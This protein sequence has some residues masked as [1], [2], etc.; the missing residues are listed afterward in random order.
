MSSQMNRRRGSSRR[1]VQPVPKQRSTGNSMM[2][3][4]TAPSDVPPT[5]TATPWN[6]LTVRQSLRTANGYIKL[7]DLHSATCTQLGLQKDVDSSSM[8][9]D[10]RIVSI[11]VWLKT[12]G[13]FG[14]FPIDFVNSDKTNPNEYARYDSNS[15]KNMFARVGFVY[16]ISAQTCVLNSVNASAVCL[17][18]LA[19]G[20]TS[21]FEVHWR[22][23]WRGAS[24][25]VV[26]Y[27]EVLVSRP[28]PSDYDTDDASSSIVEIENKLSE[29]L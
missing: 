25:K 28:A 3:H 23:L 14:L 11:S 18:F 9:L 7:S 15:M 6:P 24:T 12:D 20:A 21:A 17:A 8:T 2:G 16:P 22:I 1:S 5:I 4:M 19:A 29:V 27:L 10:Y 26:T 13:S